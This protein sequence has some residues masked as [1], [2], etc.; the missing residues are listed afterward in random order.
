MLTGK[1]KDRFEEWYTTRM[2]G[3]KDYYWL[4]GFG[5]IPVGHFYTDLPLDMQWGV[6]RST[7][8]LS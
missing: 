8:R 4:T 7:E 3:D 6:F 5:K 2:N 1:N